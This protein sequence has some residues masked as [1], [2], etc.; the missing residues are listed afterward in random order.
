VRLIRSLIGPQ[1]DLA[2]V[3][4]ANAYGHGAPQVARAA[5]EAGADALVVANAQEGIELRQA[6]QAAPIIIIGASLPSDVEAIIALDLAASLAPPEMFEA[7]R[8]E[9][10]R[11]GRRVRVHLMVDLGMRRAGLDWDEALGLAR[12]L[13]TTPELELEGLASHFPTADEPDLEFSEA[14][15]GE[16]RKFQADVEALG[17]RPR[18]VHVA[19]SA[20]L[21]RLPGSRFNLVRVGIMLYGMA[22]APFLDGLAPWR[23]VLEWR[24]R[25][26]YVRRVPAGTAVG[27]GHTYITPSA[28]VL[29]TLPVGYCD[30]FARAHSGNADVLL[31]GRRA[32]VVGRVSM[33]YITVNAGGLPDV[34]VGDVA[35]LVGRDGPELIRAEELAERR[36]TITYEVT[37]SIGQ[38]VRRVY[39]ETEGTA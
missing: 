5:V 29:A 38:R 37:C 14:M 10:R 13:T 26:V 30:G 9:A 8:S 18:Y 11:Q 2:A 6:G 7:L 17:L 4:K 15:L 32:P 28:T 16:F 24:T 21:L 22:G 39:V 35:T 36:G 3:V 34:A 27:Y 12:R 25:V 1:C 23:P 33:D 19:N 31:R 20:A